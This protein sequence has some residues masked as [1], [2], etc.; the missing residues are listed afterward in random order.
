[1]KQYCGLIAVLMLMLSAPC[2]AA[3]EQPDRS[4]VGNESPAGWPGVHV[5]FFD[6]GKLQTSNC[7]PKLTYANHVIGRINDLTGSSLDDWDSLLIQSVEVVL[8]K[9]L[10]RYF[11]VDFAFGG[12]TGS[13]LGASTGFKHTPFD[14]GIRMRQR[15]SAVEFWTNLYFYPWTTTCRNTYSSG[16][17]L[18]PFVAV[19]LGYTFFRS[20]V[21]FK[22][23][24]AHLVYNRLRSNWN[25]GYWG[26]KMMTGFN[27]NLGEVSPALKKWLITC[28][29]YQ[30]WNRLRG[31]ARMH[32]TDGLRVCGRPV[33]IDIQPRTRMDIDLTGQYYSIAVGRYF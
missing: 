5:P 11:K 3:T 33:G 30:I 19:G 2:S 6:G 8:W 15:Y 27:V 21:A 17:L 10:S 24:K 4:A 25:D 1:V 29:A 9:D 20:E 23:R 22:I 18:E 28:S 7:N 12:S 14:F 26:F 16:R 13:L 32:L 31:H